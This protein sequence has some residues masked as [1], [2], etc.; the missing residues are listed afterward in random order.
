MKCIT[1][2]V[3]VIICI[4]FAMKSNAQQ[5]KIN[6]PMKAG[7]WEHNADNVEFITYKNVDAVRPKTDSGINI[8]LKDYEFTDG[9]IEYDVE[10]T[11]RGFPGIGFRSSNDQKNTELFY[12]RYFGTV[13]PLSRYTMQYATVIDGVNMWDMTDDYQ[14]AAAIYDQRWNHVKLVISEKQMKVYVNDMNKVALYVPCFEG[15]RKSGSIY[16]TG[17]VIYANLTITPNATEDLPKVEGYDPAYSDTRYLKNW[18]VSAPVDLPFNVDI[19]KGIPRNPGVVIDSTLLDDSS[20]KPIT[21]ERRGMVNLT[22]LYGATEN[23][24]RRLVWLK[25]NIKSEIDQI[26]R[27]KLGFSDEI[28]VLIDGQ[29]L[30]IDKNYYGSPG[31]KQPRGRCTIDNSEIMLPLKKG[32]NELLLGVAHYFFGWGI[33]ARLDATDNLKLE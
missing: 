17:S 4:V 22:R 3:L 33:V 25:T 13:D 19:M 26:R 6:V 16:L 28:W 27:L 7:A 21:A 5:K 32:D 24:K 14:A 9:T 29:P 23:G 12:I 10:F 2:K 11:G 31:M 15:S 1:R 30:Y 20:W 18:S 8:M